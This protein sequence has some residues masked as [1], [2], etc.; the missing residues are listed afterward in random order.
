[1]QKANC[2]RFDSK[3]LIFAALAQSVLAK[4]DRSCCGSGG[5]L[6]IQNRT[7]CDRIVTGVPFNSH[8]CTR[9]GLRDSFWVF[10]HI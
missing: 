7:L 8:V 1:M 5:S 9:V 4:Y 3:V 10:S 2:R 6:A